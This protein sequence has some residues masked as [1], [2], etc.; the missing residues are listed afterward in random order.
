MLLPLE[1]TGIASVAINEL[2]L[3]AE[4]TLLILL[5]KIPKSEF[6]SETLIARLDNNSRKYFKFPLYILLDTSDESIPK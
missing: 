5:V 4:N 6:T 1:D 2:L 3:I